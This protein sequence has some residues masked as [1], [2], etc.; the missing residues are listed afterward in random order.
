[1]GIKIKKQEK[2]T[3]QGLVYRFQK[4]IRRSGLL[5]QARKNRF[6]QSQKSRKMKKRAALRKEQ[7][8]AEYEKLRKLG[9]LKK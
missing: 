7:L 2:E 9:T 6:R 1:M 5:F 4:S 3:S 8:K